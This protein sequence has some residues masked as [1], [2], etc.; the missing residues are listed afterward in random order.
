MQQLVRSRIVFVIVIVATLLSLACGSSGTA[1]P[2]TA[3]AAEQEQGEEQVESAE[4]APAEEPES[5][6][7]PTHTPAPTPTPRPTHT[8]VP[9]TATPDPNLIPSGTHLVGEDIQP[10]FYMGTAGGGM[11]SSCYWA[12]LSDLAGSFDSIIA[13]DNSVGRF[14]IEVK[15]TDVALETKCDLLYLPTLPEPVAEFPQAIDPGTYLVNR[16]LQPGLYRG[17]AGEGITDSCYWARLDDVAGSMDSLRANDNSI[18]LYYVEVLDSDFAFETNCALELLTALPEP[19]AEFPQAI[20][21]G[22]YLVGIDIEPGKYKGQAGDDILDSC[23]WARLANVTGGMDAL[24]ANDN[25]TGQYYVQVGAGDFAFETACA[26]ERVT[27]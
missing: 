6:P 15:D 26:L 3:P 27:E 4:E 5:T 8:P 10:G 2:T 25:A 22:T 14:Y 12:R 24:I 11:L 17:H 13:N 7:R 18:G 1:S 19:P 21:P 23:Y 16:D 9:P 20:E